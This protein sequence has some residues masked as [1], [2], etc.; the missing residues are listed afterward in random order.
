MCK[1]F[2]NDITGC[3]IY[4]FHIVLRMSQTVQLSLESALSQRDYNRGGN[5]QYDA[6]Q[7]RGLG[8]YK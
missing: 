2:Y 6:Y 7:N 8:Y 1:M 4:H 5:L 3:V